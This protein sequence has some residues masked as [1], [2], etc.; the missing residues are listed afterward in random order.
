VAFS[1]KAIPKTFLNASQLFQ[2]IGES[3]TKNTPFSKKAVPKTPFKF[4]KSGLNN[5]HIH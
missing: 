2:K 5:E 1:K 3:G 4:T